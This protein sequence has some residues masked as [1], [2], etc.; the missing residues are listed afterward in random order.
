[1]LKRGS[2]Y[3]DAPLMRF[4]IT[5]VRREILRELLVRAKNIILDPLIL[6]TSIMFSVID[7]VE[8]V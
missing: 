4:L 6:L 7:S 1:M 5:F 8:N 2:P 3:L